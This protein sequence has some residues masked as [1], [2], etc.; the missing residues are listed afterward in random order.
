M[1]YNIL[2]PFSSSPLHFLHERGP[3]EPI[4]CNLKV[5]AGNS[6]SVFCSS[7][8]AKRSDHTWVMSRPL[9]CLVDT[10]FT[11]LSRRQLRCPM[12]CVQHPPTAS[13]GDHLLSRMAA[14]MPVNQ[15][16]FL[17]IGRQPNPFLMHPVAPSSKDRIS[18][19]EGS[20]M[21]TSTILS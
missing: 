5:P 15:G 14:V 3:S 20:M 19:R 16:M 7:S 10:R 4:C 8:A 13:P 6:F 9:L 11:L 2:S 12:C 18:R 17:S 21:S 1:Q